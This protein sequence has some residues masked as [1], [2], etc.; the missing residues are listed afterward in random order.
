VAA[1][2]IDPKPQ[3]DFTGA[4]RDLFFSGVF[5]AASYRHR[6]SVGCGNPESAL[7]ADLTPRECRGFKTP[8]EAILKEL[9]SS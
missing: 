1:G 4:L 6:Q 8:F 9:G 3:H 2:T 7:T 5:L